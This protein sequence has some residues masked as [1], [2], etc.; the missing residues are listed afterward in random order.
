MTVTLVER[1]GTLTQ[2]QCTHLIEQHRS[3]LAPS[4]IT[5]SAAR[6]R[7]LSR[8]SSSYKLASGELRNDVD[9]ALRVAIAEATGCS[10]EQQE[11]WELVHYAQGEYFMAHVD[12]FNAQHHRVEYARGGQRTHSA[13]VYL[14]TVERGGETFFSEL[15]RAIVP[16]V[17]MLITWNNMSGG[18]PTPEAMHEAKPVV[19]G[20]KWVLVTW[21]RQGRW[22]A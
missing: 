18:A 16:E 12:C 15:G 4:T 10:Q 6:A 14:S 19:L 11:P 8:T 20:D 21:V 7:S 5:T 1:R 13:I 2:E 22:T 9:S 3:K 17:G